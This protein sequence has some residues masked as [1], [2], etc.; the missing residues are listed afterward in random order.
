MC[1]HSSTQALLLVLVT[2]PTI[3]DTSAYEIERIEEKK[4]L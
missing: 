4:A 2:L 1:S 3:A